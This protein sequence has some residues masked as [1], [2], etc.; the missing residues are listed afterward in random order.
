MSPVGLIAAMP[1]EAKALLGRLP[2]PDQ[3]LH[4]SSG[5]A[6]H[7]AVCGPGPARAAAAA[8]ALL[9][10]GI[11]LLLIVGVGGGCHPDLASGHLVLAET[12]IDQTLSCPAPLACATRHHDRIEQA[13]VRHGLTVRRGPLLSLGQSL[14]AAAAKHRLHRETGALA[15]DMESAAAARAAHAASVPILAL[16]AVCDPAAR[17]LPPEVM[18]FLTPDGRP[19]PATVIARL[20]RT[21]SL[22]PKL[23]RLALDYRAALASLRQAWPFI[24]REL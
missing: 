10:R 8:T 5:R 2:A 1:A 13:L 18:T 14:C 3:S 9:S 23:L 16:R 24:A 22:V 4:L 11:E 19:T 17:D 7:L 15:L 12:I 20:V 6:L 21:P